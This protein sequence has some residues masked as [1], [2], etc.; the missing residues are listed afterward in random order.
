MTSNATT[1]KGNYLRVALITAYIK[2]R[3]LIKH[4][5]VWQ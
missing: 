5:Q 4:H 1:E 3:K 2:N